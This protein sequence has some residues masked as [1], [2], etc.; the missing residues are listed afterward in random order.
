M[1]A[2][3]LADFLENGEIRNSVNDRERKAPGMVSQMS[4]A[5]AAAG[6]NI[7]NLLNKSRGKYAYTLIDL[8]HG[9]PP[10]TLEA[11]RSIKGVLSARTIIKPASSG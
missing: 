7:E 1:V 8:D 11:L 4:A 3:S 9:A 5:L 2:Q 10:A 6:L